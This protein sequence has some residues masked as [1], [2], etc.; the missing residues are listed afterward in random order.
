MLYQTWPAGLQQHKLRLD[1]PTSCEL[2]CT[3]GGHGVGSPLIVSML[4][5][6]M[7]CLQ[8]MWPVPLNLK[9]YQP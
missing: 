4:M 6:G 5:D 1:R 8:W 9:V 3:P 2:I 7:C